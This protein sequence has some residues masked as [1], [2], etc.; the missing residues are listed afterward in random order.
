MLPIGLLHLDVLAQ[1]RGFSPL[2]PSPWNTL[3]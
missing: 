3:G 1:E 2:A